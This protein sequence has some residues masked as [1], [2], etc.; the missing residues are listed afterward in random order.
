MVL[1]KIGGKGNAMEEWP[2]E[3]RQISLETGGRSPRMG[4]LLLNV[5]G[6]GCTW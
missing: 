6:F 3:R 2:G 1:E 4:V 5:Y